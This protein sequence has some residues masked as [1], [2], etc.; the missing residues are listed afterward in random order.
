MWLSTGYEYTG[1][2]TKDCQ[3]T[4][5]KVDN[6]IDLT[7]STSLVNLE[8]GNQATKDHVQYNGRQLLE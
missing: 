1:V 5:C 7:E 3:D 8:M 4:K 6:K 2:F